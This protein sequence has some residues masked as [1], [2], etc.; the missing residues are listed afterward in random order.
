M[1]IRQMLNRMDIDGEIRVQYRDENTDDFIV[2]FEDD[3]IEDA[4]DD[5]LD[6]NVTCIC[7]DRNK[8]GFP[9]IQIYVE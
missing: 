3:C 5:I 9:V 4:D 7:P 2:I 6:K 1:T 8:Y